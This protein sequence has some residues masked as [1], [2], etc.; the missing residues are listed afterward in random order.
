MKRLLKLIT[1]T[2]IVLLTGFHAGAQTTYGGAAQFDR[3][4]WDFGDIL[5]SQGPVSCSFNVTNVGKEDLNIFNVVSSCGCTDVSWTRETIAPGHKGSVS[6]TYANTDG[7]IPF[8]KSITVYLSCV[9]QPV[10]LRLRGNVLE[11]AEPLET[12]YPVHYGP[13]GFRDSAFTGPNVEQGQPRSGSILVANLSDRDVEVSFGNVSEG[14]KIAVDGGVIKAGKTAEARYT[15]TPDRS[16]WGRRSYYATP[17]ADGRSHSS[18][19]VAVKRS[20]KGAEALLH[21]SDPALAEGSSMI[22][23]TSWTKE[24]FSYMSKADKIAGPALTIPQSSATFGKVKAGKRVT[25]SFP[26]SN[27]GRKTARIYAIDTDSRRIVAGGSTELK[28]GE[29]GEIKASLDTRGLP[30]GEVLMIL[31]LTTNCPTRPLVNLYVTGYIK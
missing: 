23:I 18:T 1:I 8:D 4:V 26:I 20:A 5:S 17:L 28:P 29:A 2:A 27:S 15:I 10:I 3:T 16:H 6:V 9:R 21:E 22:G 19:G 7:P 24:D 11:K 25:V 30:K 31:S 13:L 14:L 12:L